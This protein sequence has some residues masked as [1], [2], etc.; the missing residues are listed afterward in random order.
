MQNRI[1]AKGSS[2]TKVFSFEML[3]VSVHILVQCLWSRVGIWL[4]DTPLGW[5]FGAITSQRIAC[6]PD[7]PISIFI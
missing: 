2:E 4:G 6:Q 5:I 1:R 3:V 7:V